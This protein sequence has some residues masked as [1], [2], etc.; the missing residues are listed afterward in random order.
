MRLQES[1]VAAPSTT[2]VGG[3]LAVRAAIV[4]HR[5]ER[6]DID[7]LLEASLRFGAAAAQPA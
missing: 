4:N 7:R 6:R 1:G 3:R 5:T 2:T